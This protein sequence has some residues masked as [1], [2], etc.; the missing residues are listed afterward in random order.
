MRISFDLDDTLVCYQ[1]GSPHAPNRIPWLLRGWLVDPM[2]AGA[3]ELFR[4]LRRR[5]C[6]I[7]VYTTSFRSPAKVKWWMWFY[8]AKIER[9]VNGYEHAR[10]M[11]EMNLEYPPSK[12]PAAFGIDLHIDDS[13]GVKDEGKKYGFQ[14]LVLDPQDPEWTEKVIGEVE[15]RMA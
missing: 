3:I 9:V 8:G 15:S 1:S 14:V 2:R 10:K 6:T 12:H 5:R 11:Q 4:E 7:D 13:E